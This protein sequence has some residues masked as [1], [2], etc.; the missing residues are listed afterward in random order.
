ML[1]KTIELG[2]KKYICRAGNKK[3]KGRELEK[4]KDGL[5]LVLLFEISEVLYLKDYRLLNLGK[6]YDQSLSQSFL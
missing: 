1:A 3:Q 4:I 6:C 5:N 2:D